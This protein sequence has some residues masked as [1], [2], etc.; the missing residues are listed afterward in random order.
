VANI[1]RQSLLF[2]AALLRRERRAATELA[3]V[4]T[5][6]F[7]AVNRE[8]DRVLARLATERTAG[9]M[10]RESQLRALMAQIEQQAT[11]FTAI[12]VS[13]ITQTQAREVEQGAEDALRLLERAFTGA[14]AGLRISFADLPMGVIE[15]VV[16]NLGDGSPLRALLATF[17]H[18][19]AREISALFI[20]SI[21]LG[22]SVRAIARDMRQLAQQPLQRTL[23]ISRTE[24]LRAYR[25]GSISTYMANNDVVKG[26]RWV[27]AASERTCMA[28]W[29]LDGTFHENSEEFS[30]HPNGRCT[31][32]PVT[33]SW[34]E[35]GIEGM[36][37]PAPIQ[38]GESKFL[39]LPAESQRRILG[40]AG[41]RAWKAG[42]VD[43]QDFVGVR[44]STQWG[45]THYHRSL[46]EILGP[47]AEQYYGK[48]AEQVR[49]AA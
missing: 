34:A 7:A 46:K 49:E 38:T 45:D 36:P 25:Q 21:G 43:L 16:G 27:S 30:D 6:M 22:R 20:N 26:W 10:V 39:M 11:K 42:A 24:V 9:L 18:D 33:K 37:E 19:A 41:Y 17:G 14:P 4:Y 1:Y 12:A 15:S 47:D 28:C 35:L 48:P 3:A 40:A 31:P 32:V 29:M 5:R 2:R 23:L 13:R 44:H 8:L